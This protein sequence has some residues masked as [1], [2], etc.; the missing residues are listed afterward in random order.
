MFCKK[1]NKR[2]I[3]PIKPEKS[4]QEQIFLITEQKLVMINLK[5]SGVGLSEGILI[6][7]FTIIYLY[8]LLKEPT[9]QFLR[10]YE[11]KHEDVI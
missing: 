8:C 2:I 7:F 10:T 1:G 6:V 9:A 11:K 3:F 5:N 4:T